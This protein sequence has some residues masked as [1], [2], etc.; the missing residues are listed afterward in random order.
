MFDPNIKISDPQ[1]MILDAKFKVIWTP[2]SRFSVS[3][4]YHHNHHHHERKI[5][6]RK[7]C[8]EAGARG[9]S[10]YK[11]VAARVE[12]G[13]HLGKAGTN[14]EAA[15]P[16]DCVRGKVSEAAGGSPVAVMKQAS[17]YI[18]LDTKRK[19]FDPNIKISDPQIMILDAKIKHIIIIII[20]IIMNEKSMN[21]KS[22]A[23]QWQ[24]AAPATKS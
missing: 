22:V 24:G 18:Y 17:C 21:E 23:K 15:T 20:I 10:R 19:M 8:S 3:S 2:N 7:I 13:N 4:S 16:N 6:E 11:I 1:I 5:H 9:G 14:K 12:N